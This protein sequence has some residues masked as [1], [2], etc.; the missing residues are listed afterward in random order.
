MR[1]YLKNED[2]LEISEVPLPTEKL[3][4]VYYD[5]LIIVQFP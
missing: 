5:A 3:L 4:L 1:F 2:N